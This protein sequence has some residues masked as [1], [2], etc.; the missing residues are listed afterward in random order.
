V[1]GASIVR[2][3]NVSL[4]L[5]GRGAGNGNLWSRGCWHVIA[6]AFYGKIENNKKTIIFFYERL[7]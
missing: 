6:I 1:T 4:Y 2:M 7:E 3:A 5:A